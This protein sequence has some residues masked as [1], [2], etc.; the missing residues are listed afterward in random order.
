[1]AFSKPNSSLFSKTIPDTITAADE[2]NP[3][4]EILLI[5]IF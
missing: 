5:F 1:M 4:A 3:T 2:I